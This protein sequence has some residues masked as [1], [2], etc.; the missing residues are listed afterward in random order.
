MN[1]VVHSAVTRP[2]IWG[3]RQRVILG[4]AVFTVSH[5]GPTGS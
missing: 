1:A 5:T 3:G 4:G 2:R